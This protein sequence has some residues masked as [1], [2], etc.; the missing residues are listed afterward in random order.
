MLQFNGE[1]LV[2]FYNYRTDTTLTYNM[3][4]DKPV[5]DKKIKAFIQ[6]YN[7]RVIN[8]KLSTK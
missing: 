2:G 4:N 5:S 6:Q 7:N 1:K 3:I 8:N